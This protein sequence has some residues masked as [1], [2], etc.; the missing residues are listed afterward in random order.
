MPL[1]TVGIPPELV[2][3]RSTSS[4]VRALRHPIF[5]GVNGSHG[6]FRR[7]SETESA[8][9]WKPREVIGSSPPRIWVR[10]RFSMRR[11]WKI[12][13]SPMLQI[14]PRTARHRSWGKAE[15]DRIPA[16]GNG[17]EL[18]M[19]RVASV[20]SADNPLKSRSLSSGAAN[21]AATACQSPFLRSSVTVSSTSELTHAVLQR[22]IASLAFSART[23]PAK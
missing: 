11:R 2:L 1:S 5:V 13:A 6:I 22:E 23:E 14:V 9:L 12:V 3:L 19:S 15:R 7:L 4:S 21:S 17:L 20:R 10:S 18:A 8:R 16:G